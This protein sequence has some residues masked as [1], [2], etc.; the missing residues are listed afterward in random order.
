MKTVVFPCQVSPILQLGRAQATPLLVVTAHPLWD[1]HQQSQVHPGQ[2]QGFQFHSQPDLMVEM[3]VVKLLVQAVHCC[4]KLAVV[5]LVQCLVPTCL[6]K[7]LVV[8]D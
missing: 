5:D 8:R 2:S 7:V 3:L 6:R 4:W 1:L